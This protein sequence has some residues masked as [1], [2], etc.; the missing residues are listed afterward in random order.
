[1]NCGELCN[2]ILLK[3]GLNIIGNAIIKGTPSSELEALLLERIRPAPDFSPEFIAVSCLLFCMA[4]Y[5][6]EK[7]L[8]VSPF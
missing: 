4:I 3:R 8:G 1:M 7:Y 2:R 5:I 6:N